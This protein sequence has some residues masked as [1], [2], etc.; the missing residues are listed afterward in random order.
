MLREGGEERWWIS[1]RDLA[2]TSDDDTLF[3]HQGWSFP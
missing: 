1:D 3:D 2:G